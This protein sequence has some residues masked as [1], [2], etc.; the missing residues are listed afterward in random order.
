M[1]PTPQWRDDVHPVFLALGWGAFP[2]TA[3]AV[4]GSA[5]YDE[6]AIE[7]AVNHLRPFI[8]AVGNAHF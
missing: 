3:R 8:R 7:K 1:I 5:C 4:F 6:F 2:A